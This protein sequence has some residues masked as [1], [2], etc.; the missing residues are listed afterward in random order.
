MD[1]SCYKKTNISN[2]SFLIN[3][4]WHFMAAWI[5]RSRILPFSAVKTACLRLFGAKI[6]KGV[7]IKPGVRVKFPW[8]LEIGDHCWIGEDVWIDNLA[9]VKIGSNVCVSQG[10]YF[11]TG[12]HDWSDPA[13]SLKTLPITIEEQCWIAAKAIIGSGVT[14]GKGAVLTLGSVATRNLEPMKIYSGNP[15]QAINERRER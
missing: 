13:F 7:V 5:V 14:V 11:C 6:G 1:L 15:A 10:V 8:K 3:V 4:M 2:A 9:R 12:N